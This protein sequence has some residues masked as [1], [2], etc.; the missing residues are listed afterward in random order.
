M[1]RFWDLLKTEREKDYLRSLMPPGWEPGLRFPEIETLEEIDRL[2]RQM[3]RGE[4][5]SFVAGKP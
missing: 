1:F 3:P 2:I 4:F 5:A